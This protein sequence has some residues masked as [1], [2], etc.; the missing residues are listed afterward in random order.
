MGKCFFLGRLFLVLLDFCLNVKFD[1]FFKIFDSFASYD[2]YNCRCFKKL[3]KHYLQF[4]DAQ[5]NYCLK[6]GREKKF[7]IENFRPIWLGKGEKL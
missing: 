5:Q 1:S 2:D 3:N 7:T 6:H 4:A